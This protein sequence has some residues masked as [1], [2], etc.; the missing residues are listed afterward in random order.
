MPSAEVIISPVSGMSG[1]PP[2]AMSEAVSSRILIDCFAVAVGG[3]YNQI[4]IK[5]R[6][7][8]GIVSGSGKR[9]ASVKR[10]CHHDHWS[11]DT[12]KFGKK[13]FLDDAI[14]VVIRRLNFPEAGVLQASDRFQLSVS[15]R[16]RIET[17]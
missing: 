7:R 8:N 2:Q 10:A 1:I 15:I 12:D 3:K 5:Q 14:G 11:P 16:G 9:L 4:I 6:V 13:D 17:L